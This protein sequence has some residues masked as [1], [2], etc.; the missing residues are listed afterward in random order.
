[1]GSAQSA[2]HEWIELFN[3]GASVAVDGWTLS[4]GNNLTI[5]LEGTIPAN[6]Y[7]VLERNRSD[8]GSVV[9]TPLLNYSGALVNTGATLTLRRADGSVVDSVAGGE[10]WQTIGG[11]NTTKDTAQ[12]TSTGWITGTPTPGRANATISS[13]PVASSSSQSAGNRT[14]LYGSTDTSSPT[15]TAPRQ[16]LSLRISVPSFI[17]VGQPVSFTAIPSGS[18]EIIRNSLKYR[19]NFGDLHTT[20]TVDPTHTYAYPGTYNVVVQAQFAEHEAIVRQEVTVLPLTVSLSHT[21]TGDVQ[22]H[23]DAMYEV[24]IS[25]QYLTATKV[26]KI[27][28][29]TYISP[30]ETITIPW[31]VL[32]Q[33]PFPATILLG[34]NR[35]I[36]TSTTKATQAEIAS[37]I[38]FTPSPT[39]AQPTVAGVAVDEVSPTTAAPAFG[40]AGPATSEAGTGREVE[41]EQA[42]ADATEAT[43]GLVAGEA[44][45]AVGVTPLLTTPTSS[46]STTLSPNTW[47]V[48]AV[49]IIILIAAV[50]GLHFRPKR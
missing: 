9:G 17:Y 36:L 25:Q 10:N 26:K 7:V 27:P 35:E 40:F 38:S 41:A 29:H 39:P 33:A 6:T 44:G 21:S 3:S 22:L 19:W 47:W 13:A 46:S 1:M 45:D 34:R 20:N 18:G 24:D 48:Y 5:D 32:G 15:M 37:T 50:T 2:N 11:D 12:Y 16:S 30:R 42:G 31:Q 23:N 8:G 43:A 4:D 28:P 49:F 14:I